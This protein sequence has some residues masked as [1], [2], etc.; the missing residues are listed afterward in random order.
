MCIEDLMMSLRALYC[1]SLS[2]MLVKYCPSSSFNTGI[3]AIS[4]LHTAQAVINDVIAT[5]TQY[6]FIDCR[7]TNIFTRHLG[8]L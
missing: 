3:V 5:C 4:I 1:Y 6:K 8:T 7:V 2:I